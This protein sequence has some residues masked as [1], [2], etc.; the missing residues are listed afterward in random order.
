MARWRQVP[1]DALCWRSVPVGGPQGG[2]E[3][4]G[5]L[6]GDPRR[7]PVVAARLLIATMR[8]TRTAMLAIIR[9]TLRMRTACLLWR[10]WTTCLSSRSL[11]YG[12]RFLGTEQLLEKAAEKAGLRLGRRGRW[13][14]GVCNTLHCRLLR[15]WQRGRTISVVTRLIHFFLDLFNL[16]TRNIDFLIVFLAAQAPHVIVRRFHGRIGM[17]S[18]GV[19][20]RVSMALIS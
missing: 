20:R 1:A 6:R 2:L 9:T 10:T 19:P 7:A 5:G 12:L 14:G 3:A 11:G 15:L 16:V 17:I 13:R 18:T 8:R 4:A